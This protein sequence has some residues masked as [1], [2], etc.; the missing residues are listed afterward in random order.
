MCVTKGMSFE[1]LKN[2]LV[3]FLVQ[4]CVRMIRDTQFERRH[5]GLFENIETELKGSYKREY[6]RSGSFIRNM[7]FE[8]G[9]RV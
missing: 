7:V 6:E 3:Q 9:C 2:V 1:C 4:G 5:I 8:R